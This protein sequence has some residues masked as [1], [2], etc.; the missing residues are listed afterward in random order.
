MKK[1]LLILFMFLLPLQMTWAAVANYETHTTHESDDHFGHHEHQVDTADM[2]S[3]DTSDDEASDKNLNV[4]KANTI[5]H[6][7]YG[8]TH[9]SGD[10]EFSQYL[11]NFSPQIYRYLSLYLFSYHAPPASAL[12]RP[13]WFAAI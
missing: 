12:E 3:V 8:F 9:L 6:V 13:N 2:A 4:D 7:H 5:N 10:I 11:P 1:L